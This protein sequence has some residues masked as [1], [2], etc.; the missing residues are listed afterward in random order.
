MIAAWAIACCLGGPDGPA[1]PID[2]PPVLTIRMTRPD[3]QL[4]RLIVLF[5]GSRLRPGR[6]AGGLDAGGRASRAGRPGGQPG[7]GGLAEDRR[8]PQEDDRGDHRRLE[9]RDGRRAGGARRRRDRPRPG[10]DGR[11]AWRARSP[12]TTA[13]LAAV[14][15]ALVL[16]GGS[17]EPPAGAA[18]VNRLGPPGAPWMARTEAGLFVAGSRP[19]LESA[20]AAGRPAEAG[21]ATA[22]G[23]GRPGSTRRRSGAG[24]AE[25]GFGNSPR[26][27]RGLGRSSI[28]VVASLEGDALVA[29]CVAPRAEARGP[30]RVPARSGLGRLRPGGCRG[31][32]PRGG[33]PRGR[34]ARR[35][36]SA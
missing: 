18:A 35:A 32:D 10:L 23:G 9:P 34:I 28:E 21:R 8:Q 22:S 27:S 33:R 1:Q 16:S 29:T 25:P 13:A 20:I 12:T 6:G 11:V 2:P 4:R 15:T 26:P 30:Y 5:E 19:A 36:S 24:P 31:G 17:A 14:A 3:E 7:R